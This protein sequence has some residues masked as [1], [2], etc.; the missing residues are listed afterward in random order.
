MA[1]KLATYIINLPSATSRRNNIQQVCEKIPLLDFRF[2]DAIAGANLNYSDAISSGYNQS[3]RIKYYADLELNEI[4]CFLSHRKTLDLFLAGDESHCLVLEDDASFS[5][6]FERLITAL[7]LKTVGW[8]IIKLDCRETKVRGFHLGN[9]SESDHLYAPFNASHGSTAIL[10]SRSGATKFRASM[11]EFY[12]PFDTHIGHHIF[13]SGITIA[14]VFPS[15]IYE[16]KIEKSTIGQRKSKR[17]APGFAAMIRRR[18]H[19]IHHS[20]SKRIHC[21]IT[22]SK[23]LVI[24]SK[25]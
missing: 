23:V 21:F 6:S 15:L 13:R 17:K 18:L 16:S 3:K 10:Y 9:I 8:D 7:L 5:D 20:F 14:Q 4:A 2:V 25:N 19:R 22:I 12:F 11:N 24:D 1:M